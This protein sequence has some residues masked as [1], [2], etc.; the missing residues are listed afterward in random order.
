[1][2]ETELPAAAAADDDRA[3]SRSSPASARSTA[4]TSTS[5]PGEVHA[6]LGQNGAG[7]STLIKVLAGA[8]QPDEGTITWQGEPVRLSNPLAAMQLGI[9]TIYQE[10]D[11]VDGLT[12]RGEH[13]PRPRA[14][15]PADS[16]S[17]ARPAAAARDL[18]APARPPRDLAGSRG[19]P[20]VRRRQADRQ[21]GPRA[22]PR[23]PADRH[24]RAV[25]GAR[26]RRGREP[27]PRHPRPHRRRCR[28]RLHLAPARG[29]P[30]DRATGSPCS[31]TA[32]PSPP[33]CS[34][35]DTPTAELIKL[36]TGRS[37]EY[38]FP[39]PGRVAPTRVRPCSRSR[40]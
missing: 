11:L 40:A 4:S 21:H 24:G 18:L 33:G 27:V 32:A 25:G 1:M 7:K 9:A 23:R 5:A 12:R 10:L 3:S 31:R 34:A 28:R 17:A 36:M 39:A 15:R 30:R 37:I 38:V 6:L 26:L 16:P 13:L 22:V 8:H 14:Q 35:A 29:D 2:T 20:A 19:R